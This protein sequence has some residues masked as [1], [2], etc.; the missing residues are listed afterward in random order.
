MTTI[1]LDDELAE[2]PAYLFPR[3]HCG[4]L[5]LIVHE[6]LQKHAGKSRFEVKEFRRQHTSMKHDP[7]DV[8]VGAN[9]DEVDVILFTFDAYSGR[10]TFNK[11][12]RS[13]FHYIKLKCLHRE[14][15]SGLRVNPPQAR[16]WTVESQSVQ[17]P[18][19]ACT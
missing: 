18:T 14:Q 17:V 2:F 11:L 19:N 9:A 13:L 12:P 8:V 7:I 1:C 4:S 10:G 5:D 15:L 3:E 6:L 16:Q